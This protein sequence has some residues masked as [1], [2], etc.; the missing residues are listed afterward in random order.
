VPASP[1]LT[2][3]PISPKGCNAIKVLFHYHAGNWL[4]SRLAALG[5]SDGLDVTVIAADDHDGFATALPEAEVIWHVLEP[6][7]AA[8]LAEASTLRLVQKIGIGLNTVDVEAAAARE[9]AICNM[10]GTNSQA[11]AEMALSLM[12]ACLRRLRPLDAATR[13]GRGW[14]LPADLGESVGEIRGRTVGLVGFGA[15]P[16]RLAPVLAALGAQVIYADPN[17][18]PQAPFERVTPEVLLS[19][20]DIIS[21]HVPLVAATEHMID[22]AALARMKPGAILVN[23]ARG[24]LVDY[25][26]LTDALRAGRLAGAGLDVLAS[27]PVDPGDPLLA[28]DTVVVTP[29]VA[30]LTRET[31]TRSLDIA[32]ENCRRL[33]DDRPLLHRVA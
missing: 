9:I 13:D 32:V 10:P 22:A 15:V 6:L 23:T 26:A 16:Q 21:L 20:S 29:H 17:V 14:A 7:T 1:C 28:L 3:S 12:L 27:E 18:E 24:G 19:R 11:V 2:P 8:H 31:L 33:R 30:W 5:E 25:A 4:G